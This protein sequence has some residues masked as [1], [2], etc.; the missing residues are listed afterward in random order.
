[1]IYVK[2]TRL[3]FRYGNISLK[4][5]LKLFCRTE[6]HCDVKGGKGGKGVRVM[7]LSLVETYVYMLAWLEMY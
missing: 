2:N 3:V 1:M 5:R 7:T 4:G 6:R